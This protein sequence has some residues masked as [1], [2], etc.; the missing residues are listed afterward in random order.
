MKITKR[1][2]HSSP[3]HPHFH[4]SLSRAFTLIEIMLVVAIISVLLGLAIGQLGGGLT[5]AKIVAAEADISSIG[6]SLTSYETLALR[7]PTTDQGLE[8]LVSKPAT[9]P[10]P[11]RWTQIMDSVPL[12]PWQNEYQ[13]KNPGI[14]NSNSYDLFSMGPD[15]T[16]GTEDD[17]GNWQ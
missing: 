3:F 14:H 11:R 6:T 4:L 12:D 9:G 17:I 1:Y 8:A 5:A 7:K 10:Q 16:A 2:M 13:Y 15:K